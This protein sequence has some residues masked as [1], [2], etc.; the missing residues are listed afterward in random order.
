M[1]DMFKIIK[2]NIAENGMIK[3]SDKILVSFSGGPD[4]TA[5]LYCL[6]KIYRGK[7]GP[8]PIRAS[9]EKLDI[10]KY[11]RV[12]RFAR[13]RGT[14]SEPDLQACYIN[15]NIRPN[16]VKKEIKFCR[17]F[18]EKLNIPFI[19]AEADIPQIAKEQK[20][21]IEEAGRNYRKSILQKIAHDEKCNKIALGHHLDDTIETILFR[22]FRGTGP[23]G[24]NP[25]K[26]ISG[27]FIR[28]LYNIPKSDIITF[29]NRNK[30]KYQ[31]D[32]SNFDPDFSRNYIR[33]KIIPV[34]EK[35]F[36][37]KYKGSIDR[38]SRILTDEDTFLRSLAEKETKKLCT[39]TPGGK[40]IVDLKKISVYDTCVRRRIIKLLL[41]KFYRHPG[42][43]SFDQVE[44][45]NDLIEG[46]QKAVDLGKELRV[47]A[48]RNKL[49]LSGANVTLERQYLAIRDIV[50]L[51]MISAAI[52][53]GQVGIKSASKK[54]LKGGWK[55]NIDF[56]KIAEPLEIRG[57][58][59][60]DKFRPLGL[61]GTKKIG[62]YLTDKKQSRHIR[63]E[64]V[65]I[66]DIKG[67]IWLVGYEISDR[68]KITNKTKKVLEIEFIRRKNET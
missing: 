8:V 24:L 57:I 49:I 19:V 47:I 7:V 40:I 34:I 17:E 13:S 52:K 63:D 22:L 56:D 36:G 54:K 51:P 62:D 25:I 37:P 31:I 50:E 23:G 15:H 9:A 41:E 35:H 67:I 2:E 68:V 39:I 61:G 26:P 28:P 1:K 16:A 43:G 45:V 60:G 27:I 3:K 32:K 53:T 30:I 64:V 11:C 55:I 42:A 59:S 46:R 44:Q 20:L 38:F 12:F 48:D 65:V 4:S 29:L 21:S 18:C 5:L 33:N 10:D 58:R 6:N 66:R 14:N